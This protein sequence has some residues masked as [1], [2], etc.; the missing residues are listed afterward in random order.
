MISLA[1][2]L[3]LSLSSG[4]VGTCKA[5]QNCRARTFTATAGNG[6]IEY[7]VSQLAFLYIGA[8]CNLRA[9]S[10]NL[11]L[12]GPCNWSFTST[13]GGAQFLAGGGLYFTTQAL[14]SSFTNPTTLPSAAT[15]MADTQTARLWRSDGTGYTDVQ[16]GVHPVLDRAMTYVYGFTAGGTPGYEGAALLTTGFAAATVT[17]TCAAGTLVS[18]GSLGTEVAGTQI[19]G[20][21]FTT[22]ALV[23][24]VCNDTSVAFNSASLSRPRLCWRMQTGSDVSNVRITMGLGPTTL[25]TAPSDAPVGQGA[26]FRFST[27]AGDANWMA[28]SADGATNS[29]TSTAVAVAASTS[30]LLCIDQREGG[31]ASTFWV[32]GQARLRKTTNVPTSTTFAHGVAV[33]TLNAVAKQIVTS[34]RTIEVFQ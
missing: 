1:L 11:T 15:L 27:A 2:A 17:E 5:G 19:A 31:T 7:Q 3:T 23:N 24:A 22:N 4:Q 12:G 32:N 20:R 10:S 8:V 28:C 18:V 30:Y 14:V 16:S 34:R 29:C 6:F 25:F 21:S 33:Q 26:W 13:G 9:N